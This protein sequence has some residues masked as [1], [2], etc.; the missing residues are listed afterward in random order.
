MRRVFTIKT[1]LVKRTRTLALL[2]VL[3]I[4]PDLQIFT[5]MYGSCCPLS[6][7]DL[8]PVYV[9]RRGQVYAF[10]DIWYGHI[11]ILNVKLIDGEGEPLPHSRLRLL[12]VHAPRLFWNTLE[13][14]FELQQL[15]DVLLGHLVY[16]VEGGRWIL[17]K[18]DRLVFV[19]LDGPLEDLMFVKL[20]RGLNNNV[21]LVKA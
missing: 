20:E 13:I 9:F 16:L 19:S 18:G 15:S 12:G 7:T 5:W 2:L 6:E 3:R 21:G 1:W 11:L 4:C 10:D 17:V 14:I 8:S